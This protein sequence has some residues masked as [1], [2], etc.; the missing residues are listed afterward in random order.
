MLSKAVCD[1]MTNPDTNLTTGEDPFG[2]PFNCADQEQET[3]PDQ[4]NS[5]EAV[6]PAIKS[7]LSL[8]QQLSRKLSILGTSLKRH[9]SCFGS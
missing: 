4:H 7:Q 8:P 5:E 6:K 2:A 1:A 3:V 9:F